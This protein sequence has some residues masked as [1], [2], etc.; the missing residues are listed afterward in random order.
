M[1]VVLIYVLISMTWYCMRLLVS[2][3]K[4]WHFSR[5]KKFL[6]IQK[7]VSILLVGQIFSGPASCGEAK[8]HLLLPFNF[9]LAWVHGKTD[10]YLLRVIFP[11]AGGGDKLQGSPS[12]WWAEG[13]VGVVPTGSTARREASVRHPFP[14]RTENVSCPLGWWSNQLEK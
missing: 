2:E 3:S 13:G 1:V 7:S 8:G 4:S 12:R 11:S 9:K 10:L 6:F 5:K 14:D